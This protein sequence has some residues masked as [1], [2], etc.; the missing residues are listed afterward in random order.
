M[1]TVLRFGFIPRTGNRE[2]GTGHGDK[3]KGKWEKGKRKKEKEKRPLCLFP[4]S[5]CPE[6]VAKRPAYHRVLMTGLW[7]VTGLALAVAI[8][9]WM[10]ARRAVARLAQ[11]SEMYWELKYQHLELRK[12]V[13]QMSGPET[14]PVTPPPA[15]P[16]E[17]FVPLTSLRR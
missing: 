10:K 15:S 8:A 12:R 9:A 13:E 2:K 4:L 17:S 16:N 5:L 6:P 1:S 14:S 3:G 7:L 11:L